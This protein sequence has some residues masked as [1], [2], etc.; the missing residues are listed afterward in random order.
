[1]FEKCDSS[2]RQYKWM[3]APFSKFYGKI[4]VVF[5][6]ILENAFSYRGLI[7]KP[8]E[9]AKVVVKNGTRDFFYVTISRNFE[10]F[11]YLN[12]ETNFLENGNL[13][14]KTG[15]WFFSWKH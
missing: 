1:M 2:N 4:W 6:L 3:V 12:F 15:A 8:A 7:L 5:V 10:R 13:F 9:R 14:K 11:Q